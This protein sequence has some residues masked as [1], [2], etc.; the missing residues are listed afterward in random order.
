MTN[1]IGTPRQRR[2]RRKSVKQY[3]GEKNKASKNVMKVHR[4]DPTVLYGYAPEGAR[5]GRYKKQDLTTRQ[6]RKANRRARKN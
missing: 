1:P 2:A 5:L 4:G 6:G 3:A